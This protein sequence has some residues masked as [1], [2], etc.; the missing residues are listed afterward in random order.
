MSCRGIY[1]A[2]TKDQAASLLRLQNDQDRL[3]YIQEEMEGV[4]EE[5]WLLEVDK[6][7]DAIHRCLT[8]GSL[9]CRGRDVL[10]LF[11]LGGQ[12][13][14]SGSA[15]IISYVTPEQVS[16]VAIAANDITEETFRGKYFDLPSAK[17]GFFGSRYA[18][19]VSQED[20]EYSWSYFQDARNLYR[21][22]ANAQRS[23]LF[24][25]DQ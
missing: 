13:L 19:P 14:H 20:F 24:T 22:A 5:E 21:K 17:V 8:D 2:L 9:K 15:Y 1:F 23:M 4:W 18:G 10:E 16:S 7:W 12:Q 25:V 11:V 6:A 3:A